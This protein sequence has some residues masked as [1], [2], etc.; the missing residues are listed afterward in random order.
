MTILINS[1][2]SKQYLLTDDAVEGFRLAVQNGQT[3]LALQVLVDVIDG[4]MEIFDSA[5]VEEEETEEEVQVEANKTSVAEPEKN[6]VVDTK[7]NETKKTVKA[8]S[9]EIK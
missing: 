7:K 5:L 6:E 2:V 9:E 3:R 1:E 8:E 4:I